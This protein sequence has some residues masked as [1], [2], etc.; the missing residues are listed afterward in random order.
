LG[1]Q[2]GRY[3][4]IESEFAAL[5]QAVPGSAGFFLDRDGK[6][7]VNLTD[8][9]QAGAA[10][11]AL[12]AML[13]RSPLAWVRPRVDLSTLRVH[14][15]QYDFFQL[16]EWRDRISPILFGTSDFSMLD[17]DEGKNRIAIG[18]ESLSVVGSIEGELA[19]LGIPRGAVLFEQRK[20]M[21]PLATLS[22][23]DRKLIDV[24]GLAQGRRGSACFAG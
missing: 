4:G 3:L 2:P 6:I 13:P 20:K 18:L 16:A 12:A 23:A 10:R 7:N 15:V 11:A 22:G 21:K 9:S 19:R 1:A 8:L 5:A 14:Q 24:Y 17:L